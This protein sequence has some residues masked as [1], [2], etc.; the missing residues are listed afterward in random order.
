MPDISKIRQEARRLMHE[1][2]RLEKE[3]LRVGGMRRGSLIEHYK[4]C[5]KLGC[6]CT[7]GEL[8]GP[9]WYLVYREGG[10]QVLSYVHKQEL[11][12]AR[13]LAGNYKKFQGNMARI[14]SIN[15]RIKYLLVEIRAI[16][17]G[18]RR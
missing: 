9:Y 12:R 5:G 14:R 8:H 7:R 15:A 13:G 4:K 6:A 18:K 17:L 16:R 3:N 1:R 11:R 2:S 10:R